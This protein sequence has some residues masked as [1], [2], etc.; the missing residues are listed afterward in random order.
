MLLVRVVSPPAA[1]GELTTW[2]AG[3]E[4]V[5]NLVVQPGAA[6]HPDGDGVQFVV[7]EGSAN[8][9]LARLRGMG[10]DADGPICVDHVD[11]TLSDSAVRGSGPG[12]LSREREPV[13]ELV[14]ATIRAGEEYAPSFYVLLTIAGLIGAVGILTNSQ[15]LVVGA[16]V[17]GPEYGAIIAVALAMGRRDPASVRA[18]LLAL[19]WGF[20]AAV[21]VTSLFAVAVR[22]SGVNA[23][24]VP[25][26]A[27][28]GQRADRH[29]E[30]LLRRRRYAGRDR[31]S[32]VAH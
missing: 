11:A 12:A 3:E 10:L 7:R 29:T 23:G 17:V 13:W 20:L 22:A 27:T 31:R 24:G 28:P 21:L 2:L 16:M 6:R 1:T 32:G 4:G 26:G 14:E 9:V 30:P 18:G 19:F 25:A 5:A 15:I 8:A